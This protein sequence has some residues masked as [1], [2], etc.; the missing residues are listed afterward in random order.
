MWVYMSRIHT[1]GCPWSYTSECDEQFHKLRIEDEEAAELLEAQ[2]RRAYRTGL[3][4]QENNA[5]PN[6][7]GWPTHRCPV[8][9]RV[10][11]LKGSKFEDGRWP[12]PWTGELYAESSDNRTLYRLYFIEMRPEWGPPTEKIIGSGI[13]SKPVSETTDWTSLDQTWDIH[14]AMYSGVTTCENV[15]ARWRRWETS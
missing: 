4:P 8:G 14:D 5:D 13:G 3:P 7:K 2:A 1:P 6:R 11:D 15:R 9:E 12:M 10:K